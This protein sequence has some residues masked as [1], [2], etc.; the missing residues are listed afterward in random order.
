M[1]NSKFIRLLSLAVAAVLISSIF[2]GCGKNEQKPSGQT[3]AA[4]TTKA[5]GTSGTTAAANEEPVVLKMFIRERWAGVGFDNYVNQTIQEKTNTKWEITVVPGGDLM[6]KLNVML[7]GG[8]SFDIMNIPGDDAFEL[9]LVNEGLLL[10]ISDYFDMAP[11]LYERNKFVWDAMVHNDGKIYAMN[12]CPSLGV[13]FLPIYRKDWLDK[14]DLDVPETIDDY[15]LL[16]EKIVNDDPDGNGQKD[17]Y[18]FGGR[19]MLDTR[20]YEHIFSA[21]GVLGFFWHEE[22]GELIYSTVHPNMREALRAMNKLYEMGAIDPEFVTDNEERVKE[23]MIAGKYGAPCYYYAI[24]DENNLYNYH[25]P[26]YANNP[27]AELVVGPIM[28][29]EFKSADSKVGMK[30]LSPRGWVRTAIGSQTKNIEAIMRV[31]D[32]Y[33]SEEGMMFMNYGDEG[34]HYEFKDGVVK[35]KVTEDDQKNLGITEIYL[36]MHFLPYANSLK[37]QEAAKIA[38]SVGTSSPAYALLIDE[39]AQYQQDLD[40]YAKTQFL[41]I[42]TGEIDVDEGFEEL[43]REWEKRG[44]KAWTEAMNAEYQRRQSIK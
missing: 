20:N 32:W 8:D 5:A 18:A 39:T 27:D 35:S 9:K 33:N 42:I 15:F 6:D 24:L 1:K 43:L 40:D 4:S 7:A 29:S 26:F 36:T 22:D 17:T 11:N 37:W 38:E 34:V 23:K 44:G 10:P 13:D 12:A 3:T 14:F 28:T 2:M 30:Q 16:A 31:L 19:G 25:D 41:S 21:F